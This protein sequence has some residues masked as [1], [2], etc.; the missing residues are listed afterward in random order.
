M[1]HET[2]FPRRRLAP[3]KIDLNKVHR[4]AYLHE[5]LGNLLVADRFVSGGLEELEFW[6][7]QK[8]R[9]HAPSTPISPQIL[10]WEINEFRKLHFK[11]ASGAKG[12]NDNKAK[13]L[14]GVRYGLLASAKITRPPIQ[15]L[16]DRSVIIPLLAQAEA[17]VIRTKYGI[18]SDE[19]I[20]NPSFY[21]GNAFGFERALGRIELLPIEIPPVPSYLLLFPED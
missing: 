3:E 11:A 4:R 6:Q 18:P 2:D 15:A 20:T 13:Y 21:L 1:L 16:H 5:L 8:Q 17:N 14:S 7:A 12:E 19:G 10:E 9:L